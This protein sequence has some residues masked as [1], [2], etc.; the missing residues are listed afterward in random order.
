MHLVI[1][2]PAPIPPSVEDCGRKLDWNGFWREWVVRKQGMGSVGNAAETW[3][4]TN[5]SWGGG[6]RRTFFILR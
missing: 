1:R 5:E 2:A 3:L 6:P 4:Q